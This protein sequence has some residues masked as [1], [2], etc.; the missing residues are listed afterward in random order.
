MLKPRMRVAVASEE[1]MWMAARYTSTTKGK[2]M[3][4]DSCSTDIMWRSSSK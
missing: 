3:Q 2:L 4:N 1:R